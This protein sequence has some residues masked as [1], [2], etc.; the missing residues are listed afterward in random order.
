MNERTKLSLCESQ[1]RRVV[2]EMIAAVSK[3]EH[4][5]DALKAYWCAKTPSDPRQFCSITT[6]ATH[7]AV[8]AMSEIERFL[9]N[10]AVFIAVGRPDNNL[11]WLCFLV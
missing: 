9:E 6:E 5:K 1:A 11:S 2:I 3:I 4:D 10:I 8:E 7:I